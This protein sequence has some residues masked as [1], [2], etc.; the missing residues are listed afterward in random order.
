M[1]DAIDRRL[2]QR[3]RF[4]LIHGNPA[5]GFEFVG[6][7]DNAAEAVQYAEH[8]ERAEWWVAPLVAPI[9]DLAHE[10]VDEARHQHTDDLRGDADR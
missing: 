3:S 7:F 8:S 6:P 10:R 2:V 1:A 4:V 5:D 9:T